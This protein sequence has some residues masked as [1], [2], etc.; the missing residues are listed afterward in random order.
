M[1]YPAI[2]LIPILGKAR[3]FNLFCNLILGN[4]FFRKTFSL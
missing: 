3:A 1:T 4:S 2:I